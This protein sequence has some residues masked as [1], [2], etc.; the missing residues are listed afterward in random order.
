V[1]RAGSAP[2]RRSGWPAGGWTV[3]AIDRGSDDPRLP[4]ALGTAEQLDQVAETA[5][6]AHPGAVTAALADA[7]N[8]D[9]MRTI[10]DQT[11]AH[12]GASTRSSPWPA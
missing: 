8:D 2:R 5:N 12:H 11:A 4:Y 3:V 10:V 1:R 6:A 9:A 7:S